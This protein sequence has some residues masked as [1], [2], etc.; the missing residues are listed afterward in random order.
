MKRRKRT[1]Q[2]KETYDSKEKKMKSSFDHQL[3]DLPRNLISPTEF[4]HT[5]G[6]CLSVS[7]HPHSSKLVISCCVWI[8]INLVY[9]AMTVDMN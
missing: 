4:F 2:A 9:S 7:L 1:I 5:S 3:G 8:L 6:D